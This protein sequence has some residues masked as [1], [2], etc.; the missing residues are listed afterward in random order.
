MKPR[1]C[2][3]HSR[4][5]LLVEARRAPP[6][7]EQLGVFGAPGQGGQKKRCRNYGRPRDREALGPFNPITYFEHPLYA[8]LQDDTV[9]S[10]TL[11]QGMSLE[12]GVLAY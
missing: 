7:R 8:E 6:L 4:K 10:V 1:G 9:F 2:T 3:W 12:F 5:R 11:S